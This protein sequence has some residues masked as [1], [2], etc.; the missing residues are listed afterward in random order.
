MTDLVTRWQTL[1]SNAVNVGVS[2]AGL[3]GALGNTEFSSRC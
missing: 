3:V 1:A 2:T